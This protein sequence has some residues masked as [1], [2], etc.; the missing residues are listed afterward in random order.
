MFRDAGFSFLSCGAYFYPDKVGHYRPRPELSG[1]SLVNEAKQAYHKMCEKNKSI[2]LPPNLVWISNK[3]L[4]QEFADY[5]DIIVV[6]HIPD[7]IERNWPVIKDKKVIWRTIGQSTPNTEQFLKKYRD[8]GLR[9]VRYSPME[10]NIKH[11]VG[12]D[13]LIRFGKYKEDFKPWI[14]DLLQ[15]VTICQQ[16]KQRGFWCGYDIFREATAGYP[17]K[18]YGHGNDEVEEEIRGGKIPSM[19]VLVDILSQNRVYFYTG[20]KPASYTL[21]FMEAAMAGTPIVS[22]G[23]KS[24]LHANNDYFE[25]SRL[26]EQYGGGYASDNIEELRK[27]IKLLLE[28]KALAI[29]CSAKIRNMAVELFDAE[30][31]REQWKQYFESL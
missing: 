21:N 1:C 13:A 3:I 25:V 29:E 17:T 12:E 18:L 28:D 14:G 2:E 22:I 4:S 30:K 11:F 16:M 10:R 31:I 26:L 15:I 6:M 20:T 23:P 5:F 24:A 19:E 8:E 7:L 9:V 27:Y